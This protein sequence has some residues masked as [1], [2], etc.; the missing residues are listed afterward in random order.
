MSLL[1]KTAGDEGTCGLGLGALQ[2]LRVAYDGPLWRGEE[3]QDLLEYS[4]LLAF[5]VLAGA[6]SF[7]S[8]GGTINGLWGIVNSRLAAANQTGS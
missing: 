2:R 5:I 6:A 7:I 4:L 8:M 3:G 1:K